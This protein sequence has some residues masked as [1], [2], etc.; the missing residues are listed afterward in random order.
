MKGLYIV[1]L[2]GL[3][4]ITSSCSKNSVEVKEA[5]TATV[6]SV[7]TA[8]DSAQVKTSLSAVYK[9]YGYDNSN[10]GFISLSDSYRLSEHPD[11]LAIPTLNHSKGTPVP[12]RIVL[13]NTY[14]QRLLK[15]VGITENQTLFV[16]DYTS[17][18]T[19]SFPVEN[20]TTVAYLS[21]Y[22]SP[23]YEDVSQYDYQIGFEIPDRKLSA[24][25]EYYNT[26]IAIADE[27][28]F[29][30]AQI[31]AIQWTA[32]NDK[33]FPQI[34]KPYQEKVNNHPTYRNYTFSTSAHEYFLRDYAN[35]EFPQEA[36][37]RILIVSDKQ[38]NVVFERLFEQQDGIYMAPLSMKK[39]EQNYD[40]ARNQFTGKLFPNQPE[41]IFGLQDYSFGCEP[42][43]FLA[44]KK[45]D[46]TTNCDNRH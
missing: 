8:S 18:T 25:K 29:D 17:N 9:M 23:E 11:S 32:L 38:G 22:S 30:K 20:L 24:V 31:Q 15:N 41:V 37:F 28:P 40:G 7:S 36:D 21:A 27:N 33:A 42:I 13:D 12:Q 44:K 14:R 6:D 34:S 19:T 26:F 46:I 4:L 39:G 10:V 35:K 3:F 2:I 1:V 45:S 16:Y 5:K 43:V